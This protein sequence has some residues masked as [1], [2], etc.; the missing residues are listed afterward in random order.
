MRSRKMTG[1]SRVSASNAMR[2]WSVPF[3]VLGF[4]GAANFTQ[5]EALPKCPGCFFPLKIVV[6]SVEIDSFSPSNKF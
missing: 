6:P 3:S 1:T 4:L 5:K 2:T